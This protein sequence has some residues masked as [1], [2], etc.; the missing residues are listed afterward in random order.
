MSVISGV[1]VFIS[2]GGT[3]M[4]VISGVDAIIAVGAGTGGGVDVTAVGGASWR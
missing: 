4:I 3:G 1:D 2:Y